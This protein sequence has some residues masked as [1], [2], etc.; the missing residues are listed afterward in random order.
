M[1]HQKDDGP[2]WEEAITMEQWVEKM[3]RERKAE[4]VI[5]MVNSLPE[6]RREKYREIWKRVARETKKKT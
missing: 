6:E 4:S 5:A 2:T 1:D 3:L